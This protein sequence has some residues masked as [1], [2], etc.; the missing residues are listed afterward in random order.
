MR[1]VGSSPDDREFVDEPIITVE[2]CEGSKG[3]LDEERQ[4]V[5]EQVI[6]S[7][8]EW[9]S[10]EGVEETGVSLLELGRESA[11][12]SVGSESHFAS[13]CEGRGDEEGCQDCWHPSVIAVLETSEV[14]LPAGV[15]LSKACDL[16]SHVE[17]G[18]E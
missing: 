2:G 18:S 1:S 16:D 8:L 15:E 6:R 12:C 3:V 4:S 7:F 11:I 10:A 14:V 5:A 9:D 13:D 17:E